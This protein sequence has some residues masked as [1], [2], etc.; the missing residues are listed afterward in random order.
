MC[1]AEPPEIDV[2]DDIHIMD[3]EGIATEKPGGIGNATSRIE[4]LLPLIREYDFDTE[5]LL[6]LYE[7]DDHLSKMVDIDDDLCEA[8]PFQ[9]QDDMFQQRLSSPFKKGLGLMIGQWLKS[10]TQTRSQDH[11]LISSGLQLHFSFRDLIS[12]LVQIYP[13]FLPFIFGAGL[14][15]SEQRIFPIIPVALFM[16]ADPQIPAYLLP[17]ERAYTSAA[18]L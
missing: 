10:G 18:V 4:Q 14:S 17:M 2:A 5:T 1:P 11:G 6:S 3:Q 9:F 16:R 7:L 12:H 15:L 13:F 8:L